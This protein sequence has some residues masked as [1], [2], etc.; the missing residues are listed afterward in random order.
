MGVAI[1]CP[2]CGAA[3]TEEAARWSCA[4]GHSFDR[5]RQGYAN[6]YRPGRRRTRFEGDSDAMVRARRAFLDSGAY[7]PLAAALA[8]QAAPVLAG[9][10]R[11]VV[12]DAGCGEGYYTQYIVRQASPEPVDLVAFDR[13]RTAVRLAAGRLSDARLFVADIWQPWLLPDASVD[14]IL[15]IF[16]PRHPQE[17][18]R[19]L[20]PGGTLLTAIPTPQ[21]LA[22][23]RRQAH[24]LDV[25]PEKQARLCA[26]LAA[27]ALRLQEE[28]SLTADISLSGQQVTHLLAMLPGGEQ[29]E[30][31]LPPPRPQSIH[32]AVALLRFSKSHA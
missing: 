3:L 27:V 10:Q 2:I 11:P 4:A 9:K 14:L 16:A 20:R 29:Q 15:N 31:P 17:M 30:R 12:V 7:R 19:V 1:L 8:A 5:A 13:S 22:A 28:S 21:H 23:L 32:V 18:A 25:E 6:L 24:L 26:A